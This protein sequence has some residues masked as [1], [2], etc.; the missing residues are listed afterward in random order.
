VRQ[1]IQIT[2]EFV[3]LAIDTA[4]TLKEKPITSSKH[5]VHVHVEI[6]ADIEALPIGLMKT[7]VISR[8]QNSHSDIHLLPIIT[9]GRKRAEYRVQRLRGTRELTNMFVS[10]FTRPNHP[11]AVEHKHVPKH[12]PTA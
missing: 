6:Q 7:Q 8:Q 9:D 3:T 10:A 4:S 2:E 1:S 11:P 12:R 5:A